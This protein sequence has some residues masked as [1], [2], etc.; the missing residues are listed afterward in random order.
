[1]RGGEIG[2]LGR[3]TALRGRRQ[4]R[5]GADS[6]FCEVDAVCG[7]GLR[8]EGRGVRVWGERGLLGLCGDMAHGRKRHKLQELGP[9]GA[10]GGESGEGDVR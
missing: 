7:G 3:E 4:R 2:D 10:E 9:R 6:R 8:L 1:M 5:R